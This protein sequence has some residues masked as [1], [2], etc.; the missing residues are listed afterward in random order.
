MHGKWFVLT[1][2][3]IFLVLSIVLFLTNHSNDQV[4]PPHFFYK[5]TTIPDNIAIET[6]LDG[7]TQS[8]FL[9]RALHNKVFESTNTFFVNMT[10]VL[11]LPFLFSISDYQSSPYGGRFA[12]LPVVELPFFIFSAI[13]LIRGWDIFKKRYFFLIPLFVF[14]SVICGLFLPVYYPIKFIP[15]IILV[16][17]ITFF[18]I[19][20][21]LTKQLWLKK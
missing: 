6:S 18:G 20:E 11:D 15:L 10:S 13:Y 3:S 19:V 9:T 16:Q 5:D 4:T 2:F 12:L 14:S 21:F 8:V 17:T 7:S 1:V